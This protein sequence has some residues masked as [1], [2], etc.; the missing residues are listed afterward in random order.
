[1]RA[2]SSGVIA[3]AT[4]FLCAEG[5]A[6]A[7]MVPRAEHGAVPL[8]LEPM[9][10][11]EP[12][13]VARGERVFNERLT[14]RYVARMTEDAPERP[15]P[16]PLPGAAA[17]DLLYGVR[18]QTGFA[19]CQR[20][21]V[22]APNRTVQC[23]RDF[24]D[25][26]TFDGGYVTEHNGFATQVIP[27]LLHGLAG[28]PSVAF[29]RASP[30]AFGSVDGHWTFDRWRR[31]KARFHLFVEGQRLSDPMTCEPLDDHPGLCS[32]AGLALRITETSGGGATITLA[33]QAERRLM[34]ITTS[35]A[36]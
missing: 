20:I 12:I 28:I 3:A 35:G 2:Q 5:A 32:L 1:M 4:A 27:S 10:A 14:P 31:G 19:Y 36:F 13:T 25:N 23:Y 15:R 30:A 33:G 18:L 21:D 34:M 16:G 7:Q 24:D 6:Q 11:F 17:G 26:G 22:A 9:E 8:I 29:E